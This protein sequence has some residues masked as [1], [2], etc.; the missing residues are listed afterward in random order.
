MGE[1]E[2]KRPGP[3]TFSPTASLLYRLP[4][5]WT[6]PKLPWKIGHAALHLLAFVLT[7][8][9]LVAVFQLHRR[10]KITNLYSLHSWLGIVTVFLFACQV[11]SVPRGP[12]TGWWPRAVVGASLAPTSHTPSAHHPDTA[13][14]GTSHSIG[15]LNV[16]RRLLVPTPV[17]SCPYP[18]RCP[19]V[20]P[21]HTELTRSST[22]HA[23]SRPSSP[24]S[25]F[26]P[27][28]EPEAILE[29]V[30]AF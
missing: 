5:S 24:P 17:C 25:P 6:G 4:Q 21:E 29:V 26:P 30:S 9:G 18:S 15:S 20:V 13:P 23:D 16:R 2:G 11:R 7:V 1:R 22:Y 28:S 3:G 27:F 19:S 12:T 8:L 14:Q 10:S